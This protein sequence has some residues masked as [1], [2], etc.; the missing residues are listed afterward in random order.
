MYFQLLKRRYDDVVMEDILG[1]ALHDYY[2]QNAPAELWIHNQYGPKE[3]MP[4][5]TFY[6]QPDEMPEL[7]LTA[8]ELCKGTIL[9]IGAGAGS[10]ALYLQQKGLDVC[11]LDIS[12]LGVDVMKARGVAKAIEADIFAYSETRYDTLLLLMNGIGLAGTL[13]NLTVFLDHAKSLLKPGGQLL[14]D[15]SDIAYLYEEELA[16]SESYYG[17]LW[18][19]Y[20][21]KNQKTEWFKWLYVDQQTLTDIAGKDGWVVE[22]LLVDEYNQYL[23]RL[24]RQ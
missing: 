7:E 12:A 22:I 1:Q 17:E 5:D 9:D 16:D 10:H 19:Q 8:L 6:R 2:Y 21:Y 24:T 3:E 23:A 15:S 20:E 11:A 4:V 13:D 14:F 18:Y